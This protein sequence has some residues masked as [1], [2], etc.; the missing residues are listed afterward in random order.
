MANKAQLSK[1]EI[2]FF[3]LI[4]LIWG[5]KAKFLMLGTIGFIIGLIL[6]H[7]EDKHYPK[8]ETK[9]KIFVGHPYVKNSDLIYSAMV[10]KT[11][12]DSA[13]NKDTLP[14][15]LYEPKA[16]IFSVVTDEEDINE[17]VIMF[18]KKALRSELNYV[19]NN[20]FDKKIEN[21]KDVNID[22]AV[23]SLAVSFSKGKQ[24]KKNNSFTAG[25]IGIFAGFIFAF[26]WIQ[27]SFLRKRFKILKK[28][29]RS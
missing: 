18:F 8:F 28:L 7:Q 24:I 25:I 15:Y 2:R 16:G 4:L 29:S 20:G 10:G 3:E 27:I 5:H 19:K 23:E 6:F 1:N 17:T 12:N 13:L 14:Y 26:F 21:I 22:D 11:L 9:F